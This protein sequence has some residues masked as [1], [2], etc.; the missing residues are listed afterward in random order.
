[1]QTT[2]RI[3]DATA[4]E[5]GEG[6]FRLSFASFLNYLAKRLP[7]EKPLKQAYIQRMIEELQGKFEQYGPVSEHNI[8]H[9]EECFELIYS[10]LVPSIAFEKD[11][12]W[13]LGYPI[14]NTVFYGTDS[15]YDLLKQRPQDSLTLPD[16]DVC[17]DSTN[18]NRI[19][20]AL[21]LEKIYGYAERVFKPEYQFLDPTTGLTR[22]FEI[23]V[24][25]RFVQVS[26]EG[27]LP[28]LDFS[29][30]RKKAHRPLDWRVLQEQLPL[31][32]FRFEGFSV[33]TLNDITS[34]QA[35]ENIKTIIIRGSDTVSYDSAVIESLQT[36]VGS[37]DVEFTLLP[38]FKLNGKIQFDTS[39]D[40]NC[41][42]L[43]MVREK[44]ISEGRMDHLIE[45][46]LENPEILL[47]NA[48][49][50]PDNHQLEIFREG[51]QYYQI[52]SYAL[53]PVYH[54][55]KITGMLE[56]YSRKPGQLNEDL[57]SS[58]ISATPL[59][60]QL[61]RDH[62]LEFEARINEV[63]KEKFTSIQPAVQWKFNQ[64]AWQYLQNLQ[65]EKPKKS[66]DDIGFESVYPLYGAIDI[67]NSTVERN[68]AF[69]ADMHSQLGT[70]KNVLGELRNLS[71]I[72]IFDAMIYKCD[73]WLQKLYK[74]VSDNFQLKIADFLER[75]I[76]E[77]LNYFKEED[78][79]A[80]KL[81]RVYEDEVN[82]L[83]GGAFRHR[84]QLE[85]SIQL[86][87]SSVNSYLE[88]FN[89]ELQRSY[90]C[91]FEKFRSDG[92]EYDIYMGQSIAPAKRFNMVYLK[93]ARLWQ[94][95]SMA[96]LARITHALQP[97]MERPL[98]TTQLI[99]VNA[100]PIDICFRTDERRFDVE[101]AYNI[102]YQIIKKR[103]DKVNLKDSHE[104]LTQPGKIAMV[105]FSPKDVSEYYGYISY[106][107]KEGLLLDDLE[108][109]ELEE[110]QGVNG[111]K[112]LRIGVN[113]NEPDS[114]F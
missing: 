24:N 3:I 50:L 62:S 109:L 53:I 108:E 33:I 38:F 47:F 41:V 65:L 104:R 107:Q 44:M 27:E 10:F 55:N 8:Q 35:L 28:Q 7:G 67:K 56:V 6:N 98:L 12:L 112:A 90:P 49:S 19:M 66:I 92:I 21:I 78:E 15:F 77:L 32:L 64:T 84:R 36:M 82:P 13:A 76:P 1:M 52:L 54:N 14:G 103:I 91:Y 20:Y 59:L 85:A 17:E 101:G 57:L 31:E 40:H 114:V 86:I 45:S 37:R 5:S 16:R 70:L 18:R 9:F 89:D 2:V 72:A 110:L 39:G 95:T 83:A 68:I 97:Q 94:L 48:G 102:R 46:Y 81:I 71:N 87:N 100:T 42:M 99:F 105:Y 111:L 75:D 88:M 93:N 23:D 51:L 73:F 30:L 26:V 58:L 106:L 74:E 61:L 25:N 113:V 4:R 63:I 22:Y 80:A 60:S 29:R 96:A 11:T 34:S 43:K 69:N 79:Q